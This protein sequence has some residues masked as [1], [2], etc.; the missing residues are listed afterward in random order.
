MVSTTYYQGLNIVRSH[1]CLLPQNLHICLLH[2][3]LSLQASFL[4]MAE[5]V[6]TNN[7][8][9][10]TPYGVNDSEKNSPQRN[11][12]EGKYQKNCM[13]STIFKAH[14]HSLKKMYH[15]FHSLPTYILNMKWSVVLLQNY[16]RK[17]NNSSIRNHFHF[18]LLL[19]FFPQFFVL[20]PSSHRELRL[21]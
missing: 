18:I 5:S 20:H 11:K 2:F 17:K 13:F 12:E 15:S 9:I 3:P 10:I 7:S 19:L 14:F 1:L 8:T 16:E 21:T 4:H 6:F